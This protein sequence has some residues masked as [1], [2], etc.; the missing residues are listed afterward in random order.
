M[1]ID[2][3][4][5][6]RPG[7]L[8]VEVCGQ[9]TDMAVK[10]AIEDLR[11]EA[12]KR[13]F[14]RIFL[15]TRELLPPASEMTRFLTGEHAAKIWRPPFK[16]AAIA[17]RERINKFTENVAVNRGATLAVFSENLPCQSLS[18]I[19]SNPVKPASGGS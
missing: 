11:D 17:R 6:E 16:V 2:L 18:D 14:I 3:R 1:S 19:V 9:W 7:Y 15:D 8:I 13:G 10:Q 5:E 4:Y 12:N